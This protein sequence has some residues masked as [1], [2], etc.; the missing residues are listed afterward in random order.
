MQSEHA[1]GISNG[2]PHITKLTISLPMS[3][4]TP[5]YDPPSC[6]L[7]SIPQVVTL[8]CVLHDSPTL[9]SLSLVTLLF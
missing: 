2:V 9:P 8:V 7:L 5:N 6:V 4:S 3:L 1:Y